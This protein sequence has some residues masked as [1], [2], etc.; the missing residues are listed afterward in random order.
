MRTSLL[1]A[2]LLSLMSLPI[3]A[4][5]FMT[6]TGQVSFFSSTPVEN[7]EARTQQGNCVLD[8]Q[9]GDLV[10]TVLLKGFQFE[11]ALMQEHFNEKYVE[12]DKYPKA[13]FKGKIADLSKVNFAR[14]GKYPVNVS[15]EMNL[16]GVTRSASAEGSIE[17]KGGKLILSSKFPLSPEDYQISIPGPVREK[18]AKT[19]TITVSATLDP[20]NG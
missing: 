9:T 6:K 19:L 12:S 15:G 2:A 14:D 16:H 20:L 4:Q 17:V 10:F 8:T 13:T 18:I 1:L 11:K 3:S 7:I 5:R